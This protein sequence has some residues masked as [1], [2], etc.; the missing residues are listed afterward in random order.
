MSDLILKE[1]N[2]RK[3]GG[4]IKSIKSRWFV[5]TYDSLNYYEKKDG[6]LKGTIKFEANCTVDWDKTFKIQPALKLFSPS[7]KRTYHICPETENETDDWISIIRTVIYIHKGTLS[8]ALIQNLPLFFQVYIWPTEELWHLSASKVQHATKTFEELLQTKK[9]TPKQVFSMIGAIAAA[10]THNVVYYANLCQNIIK[11]MKLTLDTTHFTRGNRLK[12]ILI[13]RNL[14]QGKIVKKYEGKTEE[15]ISD[16]YEKGSH[17]YALFWDKKDDFIAFP[18]S[19]DREIEAITEMTTINCAAKFGSTSIFKFL[20]E[21]NHEMSEETYKYAFRGGSTEVIDILHKEGVKP[22][23]KWKNLAANYHLNELIDETPD[24]ED[25]DYSFDSALKRYNFTAFFDKVFRYKDFDLVD[26]ESGTAL[27][28]SLK[29]NLPIFVPIFAELQSKL[30]IKCT[31]SKSS[32]MIACEKKQFEMAQFLIDKKCNIEFKGPSQMTPLILCAKKN[33]LPAVKFL[34]EHKA[35]VNACTSTRMTAL[36]FAADN[37]NAEM[38]QLLI[39]HG[40]NVDYSDD[41]EYTPAIFAAI[42]GHIGVLEQLLHAKCNLKMVDYPQRGSPLMHAIM[43]EHVDAVKL[44]VVSGSYLN[45]FDKKKRNALIIAMDV[46]NQEIIDFLVPNYPKLDELYYAGFP[47]IFFAIEKKQYNIINVVLNSPKFDPT[48]KKDG[49]TPLNAAVKANDKIST[50]MLLQRGCLVDE[51]NDQ[52]LTPLMQAALNGNSEII[53]L[54]IRFGANCNVYDV[55]GNTPLILC[56]HQF[57]NNS[58]IMLLRSGANFNQPNMEGLYPLNIAVLKKN[59]DMVKILLQCGANP[60]STDYLGNTPLMHSV[61]A[62]CPEITEILLNANCDFQFQNKAGFD[63]LKLAKQMNNVKSGKV[64]ADFKL[65]V[66]GMLDPQYQEWINEE[67]NK[68]EQIEI[69]KLNSSNGLKNLQSSRGYQRRRREETSSSE[70]Q[71]E[72]DSESSDSD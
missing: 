35:E 71:S 16:V 8:P 56:I 48:V 44:L 59:V 15:Q 69:E 57:A 70:S 60:N 49:D 19:V 9:L 72:S 18:P 46:G 6:A 17:L 24:S 52:G 40:A 36:S 64:I 67:E 2:A 45:Q 39:E 31:G 65:K 55:K 37:G 28:T 34:L 4:F 68:N 30:D 7:K 47:I 13:L 43:N 42:K 51:P 41:K 21:E 11:G 10:N 32:L 3:E 20:L 58:A 50:E 63:A 1:G 27:Y 14:I 22:P 62:N 54:L 53:E 26:N 66:T 12:A 33:N 61:A 38:A 5:L 25:E 29:Y 23:N